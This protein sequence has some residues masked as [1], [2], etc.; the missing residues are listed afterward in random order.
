MSRRSRPSRGDEGSAIVEFVMLG[1]LLLLPVVYL[2]VAMA[3]IQAAG[4]AAESSARAAA[5][6]MASADDDG[7][8]RRAAAVAVGLGLSDQGFDIDP[9]QA[10][11]LTCAARPCLTPEARIS[12][13]VTVDVRLPGVPAF[14][15]GLIPMHSRVSATQV[16]MVDRF[17]ENGPAQAP[18]ASPSSSSPS[19]PSPSAGR[20]P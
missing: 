17:R 14:L 16:T 5:R 3:R 19:T 15:D 4:Y 8:G 11:H 10:L 12:A 7:S 9:A 6:A 2:I 1:T 13:T 20:T 18:G